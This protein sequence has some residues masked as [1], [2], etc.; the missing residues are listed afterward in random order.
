[1]SKHTPGRWM[2]WTSCSWKRL[3]SET[4]TGTLDVLMPCV[5][6]SDGHP[7]IIVSHADMSLIAAAPD[8]LAALKAAVACGMVPITSAEEGGAARFSIQVC[9]ADMIR[10][11]IAKAE[12][13]P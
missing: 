13:A 8:M 9:V 4:D 6:K 3:R 2:W 10:A 7:D 1:M 12:G 5:A 11:A